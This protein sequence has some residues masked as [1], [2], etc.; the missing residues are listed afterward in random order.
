MWKEYISNKCKECS[1]KEPVYTS[2]IKT[3]EL[4]LGVKIPNQLLSFLLE[5]NGCLGEYDLGL[6]WSLDKIVFNNTFFRSEERFRDIY[7]AFDNL[8]FFADAGNGSQFFFPISANKDTRESV[9]IWSH[10]DDS[11]LWVAPNLEKY[12][13]WW[14]SGKIK[15]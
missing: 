14:L 8:L 1:F 9:F 3:A 15:I 7:M 13:D 6:I 2:E 4:K 5:T 12:I 11:R 10:E